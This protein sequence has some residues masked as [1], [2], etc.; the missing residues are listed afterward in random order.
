MLSNTNSW[1]VRD[2]IISSRGA[3]SCL[4]EHARPEHSGD[5]KIR[6][7]IGSK[8]SPSKTPFGATTFNNEV[9]S[10]KTIEFNL[11]DEEVGSVQGVVEWLTDYLS[12]H[13][14][15]IFRKTMT[16]EQVAESFRSPATQRGGYQPHLRCKIR[17]SSVRVWDSSGR[18]REGGLPCDLRGYN[19]VPRITL[20][21][22]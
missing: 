2:A 7:N 10:Q 17:P 8:D 18:A 5:S 12:Q 14:E 15:R 19:L 4:V 20:E 9:S 3:K 1:I 11:T 16:R 21:K 22:I 6:F 13:S